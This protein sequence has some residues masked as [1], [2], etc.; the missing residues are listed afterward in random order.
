[1]ELIKELSENEFEEME[2]K[3]YFQYLKKDI[4]IKFDKDVPLDY[5]YKNITYL[6]SIN[7]SLMLE[8]CKYSIKFCKT[9]MSDYPDVN[10]NPGLYNLK[11]TFDILN[12]MDIIRLKVDMYEDESISV[13]NLSGSCEW[14]KE[15]GIQWLIKEDRLVY[16]GTWDDL[17]IWY[18]DLTDDLTNYV[19]KK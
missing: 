14:D 5:V 7:D 2:G 3:V 18:S 8:L 1:M 6:N 12:Y 9:I 13:L 15:N 17:N 10:Y 19:C 11:D 16:V 4:Y